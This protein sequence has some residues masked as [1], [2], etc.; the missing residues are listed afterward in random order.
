MVDINQD[1]SL[2]GKG[3]F[4]IQGRKVQEFV[5]VIVNRIVVVSVK[6]Q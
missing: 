3:G 6:E 2:G 4:L 1:V 5:I